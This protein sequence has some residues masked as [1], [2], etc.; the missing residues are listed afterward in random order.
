MT[1]HMDI[2]NISLTSTSHGEGLL[3][4]GSVPRQV[5]CSENLGNGQD[6]EK[7]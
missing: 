5:L 6:R 4:L 2:Y 7:K 3:L 1:Y